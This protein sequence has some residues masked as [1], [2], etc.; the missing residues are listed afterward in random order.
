VRRT[1]DERRKCEVE[2]YHEW[3]ASG[4]II[5]VDA[6]LWLSTLFTERWIHPARA[7]WGFWKD[8]GKRMN[9]C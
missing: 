7:A 1:T 8:H 6:A 2:E 5:T 3:V 4:E 9:E